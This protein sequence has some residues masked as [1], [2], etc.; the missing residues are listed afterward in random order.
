MKFEQAYYTWGENQLS[1]Y[2]RGLGICAASNLKDDFLDKCLR[3]GSV[4]QSEHTNKTAEFTLY[5]E[6]FR[7]FVGV[8]IS[9]RAEGGDKRLNKLCHFF[10]PVESGKEQEPEEYYLPYPYDREIE[11]GA[12]VFQ[13]E[14]PGTEYDYREILQKY[15]LNRKKLGGLLWKTYPYAFGEKDSLI[16]VID[17]EK[18][19]IEEDAQIAREITWLLSVLV[20]RPEGRPNLYRN[21]LSYGVYTTDNVSAVRFVFTDRQQLGED[22]YYLDENYQEDEKIPEVYLALADSALKSCQEVQ[23]FLKEIFECK[24]AQRIQSSDLSMMYYRWKLNHREIVTQE[25]LKEYWQGIL[26]Q[27]VQSKWYKSFLMDYLKQAEKMDNQSLANAWV[28]GVFPELNR[29]YDDMTIEEQESIEEVAAKVISMIYEENRTNYEVFIKKLTD[30]QKQKVLQKIYDQEDSCIEKDIQD[31]QDIQKLCQYME[32][33]KQLSGE[34]EFCR[35]VREKALGFYEDSDRST[36]ERL[37]AAMNQFDKKSWEAVMEYRIKGYDTWEDYA[38]Y[39]YT[40]IPRMESCQVPMHFRKLMKFAYKVTGVEGKNEF[41]TMAEALIQMGDHQEL[42]QEIAE[43]KNLK[44][45]WKAEMQITQI[46]K[47]NLQELA[48]RELKELTLEQAREEWL[49]TVCRRLE[50]QELLEERL[51][52]QLLIKAK[53]DVSKW[54]MKSRDWIRKYEGLLWKAASENM[55]W[56]LHCILI[57]AGTRNRCFK[58]YSFW[59]NIS[60]R[61][62]FQDIYELLK[63]CERNGKDT[64]CVFLSYEDEEPEAGFTR[65]CYKIWRQVKEKGDIGVLIR[66]NQWKRRFGEAFLEFIEY[67]E[68]MILEQEGTLTEKDITNFFTL[69]LEEEELNGEYNLVC[70]KFR[71]LQ[72]THRKFVMLVNNH[73]ESIYQRDKAGDTWLSARIFL[74]VLAFE[75][76]CREN[77]IDAAKTVKYCRQYG[78]DRE[79]EVLVLKEGCEQVMEEIR[80]EKAKCEEAVKSWEE[81]INSIRKLIEERE[82]QIEELKDLNSRDKAEIGRISGQKE[83]SEKKKRELDNILNRTEDELNPSTV[84]RRIEDL[85]DVVEK[86]LSEQKINKKTEKKAEI[87]IDRGIDKKNRTEDPVKKTTN[88]KTGFDAI[89]FDILT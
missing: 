22:R 35:D 33:Y 85:P 72:H 21:R 63:R 18:H 75:E 62:H 39:L 79:K 45:R 78:F 46:Q 81:E 10:I 4:F 36:R 23:M 7:A 26:V 41:S 65:S 69:L 32:L 5:S 50:E 60:Y 47:E 12:E 40:E 31:A 57:K 6:E 84:K 89:N 20:P 16:F 37:T 15:G 1:R 38:K 56:K 83:D 80:E 43:F 61:K 53:D 24:Y 30:N 76:V 8:G 58:D 2:K 68:E 44:K 25:D 9:P 27:V 52:G 29:R 64:S 59:E 82:K 48:E 19:Q 28:R 14:I 87:K 42:E 34:E 51:Y 74:K 13:I 49:K 77:L 71:E 67:L 54:Q 88:N 11:D 70:Q 17:R 86:N 3:L 55:D 73:K 66:K